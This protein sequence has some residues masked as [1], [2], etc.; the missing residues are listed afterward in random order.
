MLDCSPTSRGGGSPV[1]R[2][3]ASH[4][5]CV[6]LAVDALS[7]RTPQSARYNARAPRTTERVDRPSFLLEGVRQLGPPPD[8]KPS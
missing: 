2:E 6:S 5:G 3:P 1:T 8:G 7:R 4:R